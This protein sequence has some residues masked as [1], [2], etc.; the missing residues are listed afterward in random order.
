MCEHVHLQGSVQCKVTCLKSC[1]LQGTDFEIQHFENLFN[2]EARKS[3][4]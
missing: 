4:S 2:G 1:D 3:M